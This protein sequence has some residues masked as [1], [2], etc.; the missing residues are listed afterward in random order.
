[1]RLISLS[2]MIPRCFGY[3]SGLGGGLLVTM[4]SLMGLNIYSSR[5]QGWPSVTYDAL[6]GENDILVTRMIDA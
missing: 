4:A 3:S 5:F 1:M 6:V 2:V